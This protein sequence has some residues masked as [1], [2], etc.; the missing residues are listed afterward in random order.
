MLQCMRGKQHHGAA[1]GSLWHCWCRRLQEPSVLIGVMLG[2]S[3]LS[4]ISHP[5]ADENELTE[6]SGI[7]LIMAI[8]DT[9]ALDFPFLVTSCFPFE[10]Q[11]FCT[12]PDPDSLLISMKSDKVCDFLK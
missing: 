10:M 11:I 7:S 8:N 2:R 6:R 1:E 9:S 12:V 3:P 5:E 4:P